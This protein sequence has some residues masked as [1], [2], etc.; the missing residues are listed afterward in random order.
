MRRR[1]VLL[2]WGAILGVVVAISVGA[3]SATATAPLATPAC[4]RVDGWNSAGTF[5]PLDQGLG[6]LFECNYMVPGQAEQLTLGVIWIKP[7]ARDVDVDYSQCGR[8]PSG[9][10]SDFFIYSGKAL[11]RVEYVVSGGQNDI[12][13]LQADRARIEAA[14][15]TLLNASVTLAKPCTKSTTPPPTSTAHHHCGRIAGAK[16]VTFGGLACTQARRIYTRYTSHK[17]LP[18]GWTC[19]LSAREC[20]NGKRGFTFG[21]N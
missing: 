13:V 12:G 9:S 17:T 4:P 20:A 21:L 7:S 16:I 14:A 11:T 1:L 6:I 2:V 19:G 3:V 18:S 10:G 8:G 5:G 15:T